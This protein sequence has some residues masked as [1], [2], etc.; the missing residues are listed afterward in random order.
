[1]IGS[2]MIAAAS[3][4]R[5][6]VEHLEPKLESSERRLFRRAGLYVRAVGVWLRHHEDARD[7]HAV[8]LAVAGERHGAGATRD[9]VPG[10][11]DGQHL[12]TPGV[13]LGHAQR[14]LVAFRACVDEQRLRQS[15]RHPILGQGPAEFGHHLGDH[16]AEQ[17]ECLGAGGTNR[18]DDSGVVVADRRAHLTGGE[19]ENFASRIVPY[20]R[21]LRLDEEIREDVTA[22]ADQILLSC[23]P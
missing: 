10:A 17:V 21:A 7:R 14:R 12:V 19:V 1:M 23:V 6:H 16:A 4:G 22:I 15:G 2:M 3:A 9:A 18:F 8:A 11:A 5:L 20:D 13:Q